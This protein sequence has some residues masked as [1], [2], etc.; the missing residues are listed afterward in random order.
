MRYITLASLVLLTSSTV[1]A[2]HVD[3]T[4]LPLASGDRIQV[5]LNGIHIAGR[6]AE[7]LPTRLVL[8]QTIIEVSTIERID[9]VGDPLTNGIYWGAAL[10]LWTSSATLPGHLI[11]NAVGGAYCRDGGTKIV[12]IAAFTAA[13]AAVGG[14]IDRARVG[15]ATIFVQPSRLG[16]TLRW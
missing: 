1:A 3:L 5:T 15:R 6:I 16:V 2:Q 9:K 11:T 13:S 7:I 10:G 8:D 4:T 12:C 14:L